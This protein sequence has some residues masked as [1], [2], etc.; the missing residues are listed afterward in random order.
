[1]TFIQYQVGCLVIA[2]QESLQH[3]ECKSGEHVYSCFSHWISA[4]IKQSVADSEAMLPRSDA[5]RL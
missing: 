5:R 2:L 3:V 4:V 1:M